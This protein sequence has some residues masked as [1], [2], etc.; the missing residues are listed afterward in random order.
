MTRLAILGATGAVGSTLLRVLEERAFPLDELRLLASERSAGTTRRFARR[1][2]STVQ[3]VGPRQLRRH[4]HRDL[5]GRRHA[6]AR[7]G[8]A[9]HRRGRRRRRQL[10]GVPHG[11]RR[12]ARRR[13]RQPARRARARGPDR[14]PELLDDA[15][16]AGAR[17]RCTAA[18]RSSTSRSRPTSRSPA[19]G[20]KA[21]DGAARPSRRPCSPARS[22]RAGVYPHRIAFNVLPFAGSLAG[23]RRLHRRGAQARQRVAQDPRAARPARERDLRARAGRELALR[24]RLGAHARADR[25]RRGARAARR[26]GRHHGRR[27]PGRRRVPDGDRRRRPGRRARRPHPPRP[28]RPERARALGRRRQPAQGRGH[29]RRGDRRAARARPPAPLRAPEPMRVAVVGA[30]L[31]G[32]A[33]A[34][35]LARAGVDVDGLRGAR[36]R[37]RPRLVGAHARR[38]ALR[39]RRRVRRGRLRPLSPSRRRVRP[40]A[41]PAGVRVRRARGALATARSLP[42]LLLEA[43]RALAATVARS[44]PAPRRISA[45]D[46]L[47]RT[48]L[49]P[50]ARLA[51]ARRLE[52]TYTVELD[53]VSAAWLASAELRAG[54]LGD[55]QPSARLAGGNDALAEG[56]GGG[57]R[58]ARAPRLPVDPRAAP[59]TAVA[60][61]R[62]GRRR[63]LRPRRAR[64]AAAARAR[65]CCRR[66]AS[67]ASY[68][69]LQWGVRR[70]AARAARRAGRA[71]RGAGPRG[72]VLDV[73]GERRSRRPGDV[74]SSFAGGAP[75]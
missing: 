33:C 24:G 60:H 12:A 68:A 63:A 1:A 50:L 49:E 39:A 74:A 75:R 16:D 62:G 31:A 44:A 40:A 21:I 64:R 9:G 18:R 73:D 67:A 41:R 61:R 14:Q 42:A 48:P 66:C 27:R 10:L 4:R 15:A 72:G 11:R 38:R 8:A 52:G 37:R 36:P 19:P 51:L 29:E 43:E 6:L 17:G 23:R 26:R 65:R 56:A 57:A 20:Q 30:G 47:A 25:A 53:H 54:E 32:L 70:Q 5:L 58:R 34:V 35:D 45:A 22:R 13:R 55:E 2:S 46:A 3:A 7:V 71:R 28:R 69:R 59:A